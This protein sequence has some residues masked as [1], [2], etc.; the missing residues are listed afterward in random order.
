[1]YHRVRLRERATEGH[2]QSRSDRGAA[3]KALILIAGIVAGGV[4]GYALFGPGPL[5]VTGN[6]TGPSDE[7]RYL[8]VAVKR[9]SEESGLRMSATM[10]PPQSA[11]L[12]GGG[13]AIVVTDYGTSPPSGIVIDA[14]TGEVVANTLSPEKAEAGQAIIE[15]IRIVSGPAAVWPVADVAPSQGREQWGNISY[16]PPDPASGIL[17]AEKQEDGAGFATKVVAFWNGVSSVAVLDT[18]EVVRQYAA[19]EDEA[20]FERLLSEVVVDSAE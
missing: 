17:V 7:L 16:I 8:N 5:G 13:P 12:P 10:L 11:A 19:A 1:M 6:Q 20:A 3:T 18:G 4:A 15:S 14:R 2:L 9:P